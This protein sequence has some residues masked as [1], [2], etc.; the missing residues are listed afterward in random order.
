MYS[1]VHNTQEQWTLESMIPLGSMY[2]CPQ[3]IM[4]NIHLGIMYHIRVHGTYITRY[5]GFQSPRCLQVS[6]T[7]GYTIC[8]ESTLPPTTVLNYQQTLNKY[9]SKILINT[10]FNMLLISK[11]NNHSRAYANRI[12]NNRVILA[13]KVQYLVP[14]FSNSCSVQ[15]YLCKFCRKLHCIVIIQKN[16]NM[17]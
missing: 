4:Y 8:L 7:L 5:Y 2:Q 1:I 15:K 14:M 9:I 17:Q 11:T 6:W 12:E 3:G 10:R 16:C 13:G